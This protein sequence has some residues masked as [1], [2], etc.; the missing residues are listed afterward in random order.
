MFHRIGRDGVSGSSRS[1]AIVQSWPVAI[2]ARLQPYPRVL[3]VSQSACAAQGS[4]LARQWT[5]E[6]A[7]IL[8]VGL[9]VLEELISRILSL[10]VGPFEALF[11]VL[12]APSGSLQQLEVNVT[13]V[14]VQLPELIT[15]LAAHTPYSGARISPV[16]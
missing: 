14:L 7:S 3:A 4:G 9:L 13:P 10:T 16:E 15:F 1:N 5:A 12:T 8:P 6:P 2:D 11:Q